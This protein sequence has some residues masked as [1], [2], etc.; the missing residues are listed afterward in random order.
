MDTLLKK[1]REGDSGAFTAL[2]QAQEQSLWRAALAILKNEADA[3]DAMQDT[4]LRAWQ[5]MG[6]VREDT[7]FKAWVTR[8]LVNRC[9]DILRGKKRLT[10]LESVPEQGKEEDRDLS[11]DVRAVLESLAENDRLILTLF[12]LDDLSVRQI[13]FVMDLKESAV[14]TRLTRAR[15]RFRRQYVSCKEVP[16]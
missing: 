3:A 11:L 5:R 8:I 2:M 6:E 1:A 10:S 15:E 9:C 4:A 12:Y 7:S 14:H 13:A 16:V